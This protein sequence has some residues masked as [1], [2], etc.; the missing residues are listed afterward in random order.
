VEKHI[1]IG[2]A[3]GRLNPHTLEPMEPHRP[4]GSDM[5]SAPV[6]AI[7]NKENEP[8][9]A[10]LV[11]FPMLTSRLIFLRLDF[12]LGFPSEYRA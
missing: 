3:T 5:S 4:D 9:N 6:C 7:G 8:P 10:A 2:I 11:R 1:A 12:F